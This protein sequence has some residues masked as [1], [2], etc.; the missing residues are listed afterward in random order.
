MII[1]TSEYEWDI[2]FLNIAK[3]VSTWSKDPTTKVGAILVNP[4]TQVILSTGCNG[5]PRKFPDDIEMLNNRELKRRITIHAEINA[6]LNAAKLGTKIDNATLY[7]YGLP[8]CDHCA[9]NVI[10]AGIKRIVMEKSNL[11]ITD[12]I[13]DKAWEFS[14]WLFN[15]MQIQTQ[16][17]ER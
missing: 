9:P 10:Q 13:W 17:I 2:R 7:V 14:S 11:P 1:N 8:V 3:E 16:F 15:Q 12:S 6:I 4:E 5:F